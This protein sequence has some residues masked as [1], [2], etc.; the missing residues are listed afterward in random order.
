MKTILLRI[1]LL[2]LLATASH[3]H[4]A[5]LPSEIQW[6]PWSESTFQQ[7][8][9]EKKLLLLHLGAGWCHW[10]H[11]MEKVTYHDPEVIKLLQQNFIAI[12]VDQ[13]ERPDISARYEDW[14]WPAT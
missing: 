14:G 7:A 2:I 4:A 10:C 5:D 8:K 9:S 1:S 12:H 13:D 11:V 6:H 3:L